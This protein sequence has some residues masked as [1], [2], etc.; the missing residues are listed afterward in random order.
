MIESRC[1][2]QAE[3]QPHQTTP[4]IFIAFELVSP[5]CLL[6]NPKWCEG[7]AVTIIRRIAQVTSAAGC[8]DRNAWT[9]VLGSM[10]SLSS[11]RLFLCQAQTSLTVSLAN[12]YS[13]AFVNCRKRV[14]NPSTLWTSLLVSGSTCSRAQAQIL[15]LSL[16]QSIS[17][18][19]RI[20]AHAISLNQTL[21]GH[22]RPVT[23]F[24]SFRCFAHQRN[25]S[26]NPFFGHGLQYLQKRSY[27][28]WKLTPGS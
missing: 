6:V 19:Q 20:P 1:V 14:W 27:V 5:F 8:L 18:L 17:S 28:R 4:R 13:H 21:H 2:K 3:P 12:N 26:Y 22:Y 11:S 9:T 23:V 25:V 16:G 15:S 24:F 10:L 7:K